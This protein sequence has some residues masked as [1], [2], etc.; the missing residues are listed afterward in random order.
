MS[1]DYVKF[2]NNLKT[3]HTEAE[4]KTIIMNKV[5]EIP[6]FANLKFD[7]ELTLFVCNL[8]E[9]AVKERKIKKIDK[10]AFVIDVLKNLFT[11]SDD[12]INQIESQIEFLHANGKI[13]C[14][15]MTKKIATYLYK[16]AERK[17]L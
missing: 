1:L 16:W 8:I 15:N 17:I 11:F 10:R 4:I 6:D 13:K 2:K 3:L 14:V 5:Q 12:E 9:N 7:V